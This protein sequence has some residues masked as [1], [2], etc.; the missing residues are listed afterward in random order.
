MAVPL[1]AQQYCVSFGDS[2]EIV[3]FDTPL[4]IEE[5]FVPANAQ[6]N[7]RFTLFEIRF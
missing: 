2:K 3:P 5:P 7:N 1:E 6:L 4:V